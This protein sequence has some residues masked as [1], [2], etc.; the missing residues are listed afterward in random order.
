[1]EHDF[2]FRSHSPTERT[3]ESISATSPTTP[4]KD[5]DF[6]ASNRGGSG[7]SN[8]RF[9]PMSNKALLSSSP[10]KSTIFDSN[11]S[12]TGLKDGDGS[13]E[14]SGGGK[15]EIVRRT[16]EPVWNHNCQTKTEIEIENQNCESV[17][18]HSTRIGEIENENRWNR[19]EMDSI[20]AWFVVGLFSA[21]F[22]C[23]AVTQ[24]IDTYT[25][26]SANPLWFQLVGT[27]L[28]VVHDLDS[29]FFILMVSDV[30]DFFASARLMHTATD[31]YVME[32]LFGGLMQIVVYLTGD[33][34]YIYIP[35]NQGC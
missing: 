21:T 12:N 27:A 30:M 26:S 19:I 15:E 24:L 17:R 4:A 5:S 2:S 35:Q 33:N 29:M 14:V 28:G 9:K 11:K 31:I 10:L 7:E 23:S 25:N 3:G 22:V 20:T 13:L 6:S 16:M 1:M 32:V 34:L 8:H 18:N